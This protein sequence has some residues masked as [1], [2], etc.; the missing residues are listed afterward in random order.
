MHA[1][2]SDILVI[3]LFAVFIGGVAWLSY[4]SRE[5]DKNVQD[6]DKDS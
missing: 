4:K 2:K 3:V 1:F 6:E 5:N